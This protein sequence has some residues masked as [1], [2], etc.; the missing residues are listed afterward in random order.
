MEYLQHSREIV[1]ILG[2]SIILLG[3]LRGLLAFLQ[4]EWSEL[5]GLSVTTERQRLR[6]GLGYYL[7]LG[8]EILIAADIID[9]LLSPS[10][11]ELIVLGT[12]V[13]L[14]TV[15]SYSLNSELRHSPQPVA[16]HQSVT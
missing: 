2:V 12:V 13:I 1:G 6:M 4:T 15:I 14:R 5:R 8:L 11:S 7:L 3:V 16:H 10:M 9:T